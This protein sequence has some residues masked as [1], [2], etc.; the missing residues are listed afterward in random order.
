MTPTPEAAG[1]P[2]LMGKTPEA[3]SPEQKAD[4]ANV[5]SRQSGLAKELQDLQA[6]MDD[7]AKR[8]DES[9]PLAAAAMREAAQGSRKQ[10]TAPKMGEAADQLEKNQMGAAR[11]SQEQVRQDLK[12]LVDSIQNR[13]ERELA[14]LVKELKNAEKELEKLRER[15]AENLKKTRAAQKNPDAKARA[16]QLQKLAKEQAEIQKELDRQLKR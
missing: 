7:M 9:D 14:R 1:K 3:L 8:L 12:D 15:Q 6:K 11:N 16:D 2:D 4:L 5:A 13:R 10:G